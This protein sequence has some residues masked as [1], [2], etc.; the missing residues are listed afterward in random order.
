MTERS[1]RVTIYRHHWRFQVL[2]WEITIG[3][4][5]QQGEPDDMLDKITRTND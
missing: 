5:T 3:R 1:G 4:I 2:G